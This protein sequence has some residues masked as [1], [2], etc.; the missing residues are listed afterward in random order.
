MKVLAGSG[1]GKYHSGSR[2]KKSPKS[3][4]LISHHNIQPNTLTR[5]YKGKIYKKN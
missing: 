5:E 4:K 2:Q 3:K 1:S